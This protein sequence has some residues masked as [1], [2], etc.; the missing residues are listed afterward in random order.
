[1]G[2]LRSAFWGSVPSENFQSSEVHLC[3]T[4]LCLCRSVLECLYKGSLCPEQLIHM[5][6]PRRQKLVS[7]SSLRLSWPQH[8]KPRE[9]SSNMICYGNLGHD[10]HAPGPQAD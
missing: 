2:V 3:L 6:T 9:R 10:I 1:M 5:S 8:N 4:I 7:L